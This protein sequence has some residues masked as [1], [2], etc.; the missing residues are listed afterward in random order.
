[1]QLDFLTPP[2]RRLSADGALEA[3]HEGGLLGRLRRPVVLLARNLCAYA[4]FEAAA[5]PKGRRAQAA[6]LYARTAS[7]Y[8][9]SGSALVKSGD[10]YGVWWWDLERI[11][12]LIEAAYGRARPRI[13]PE[14]LAQPR[15][16]GWRIVKLKE[17]Y[18]AQ[19]WRNR[20]L[21]ASTWRRDRYDAAS[22]GAFA[23]LQRSAEA[24]PAT[25]PPAE[26]LPLATD[27]DA[28]AVALT[29]VSREQA[30]GGAAA[31]FA[32]VMGC[33]VLF[34]LGQGVKLSNDSAALEKDT[35]EIRLATPQVGAMRTVELDRQKLVAYRQVEERTNPVSAT[36]AAIGIVAIHDLTPSSVDASEGAL[37]V[38][39]PYAALEKAEALVEEFEQSGYFFD[40]QPRA[41]AAN[42]TLIFEMKVREAAPPLSAGA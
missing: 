2:V 1:M 10:D 38:T 34:L 18:E 4:L 5:L 7:P 33:S 11:S 3:I 13:R 42:Q 12:P 25:P 32:L 17:G 27:S 19:L 35:A 9:V 14:T 26:S 15:G 37:S 40:V 29:E 30:M 28:F 16:S 8:V 41:D 36:G 39:L 20:G 24:A 21:T 6:A 31:A 23:R 22:W